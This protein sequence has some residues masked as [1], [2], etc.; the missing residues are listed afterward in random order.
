MVKSC[1]AP[2]CKNR[3]DKSLQ[4]GVTFH[5]FPRN[6]RKRQ[7]WLKQMTES[8]LSTWQPS[9]FSVIC[10]EHFEDASFRYLNGK[11]LVK[12]EAFPTKFSF[13]KEKAEITQLSPGLPIKMSFTPTETDAFIDKLT[14]VDHE[15]NN[16]M[17]FSD[18]DQTTSD[19]QDHLNSIVSAYGQDFVITEQ[20]SQVDLEKSGD[21]AVD[22]MFEVANYPKSSEQIFYPT[23]ANLSKEGISQ[24]IEKVHLEVG[25]D[26]TGHIQSFQPSPSPP[27]TLTYLKSDE[28]TNK[29]KI[30]S[31]KDNI[32]S[33]NID[34]LTHNS[35][36][37]TKTSKDYRGPSKIAKLA[38]TLFRKAMR[39]SDLGLDV[40]LV[41]QELPH[42]PTYWGTKRFTN[43]FILSKPLV[44]IKKIKCYNAEE[45]YNFS[46][47]DKS[48]KHTVDDKKTM[49]KSP[50]FLDS[51]DHTYSLCN[52]SKDEHWKASKSSQ[53]R[54]NPTKNV[55]HDDLLSSNPN[56]SDLV[57]DESNIAQRS[58][59]N[60]LSEK[61]D[62][63]IA[64]NNKICSMWPVFS[65]CK[66]NKEKKIFCLPSETCDLSANSYNTKDCS[67]ND[68]DIGI[69]GAAEQK[70]NKST[71]EIWKKK[72]EKSKL[73]AIE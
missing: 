34:T 6:S 22:I 24:F 29:N 4:K 10:S 60:H 7:K 69:F 2:N 33:E 70:K 63:L 48:K 36:N 51:D 12:D 20:S 71:A 59:K 58:E 16:S 9:A 46:C 11:R 44:D 23:K 41:V 14:K 66:P 42:C 65:A 13:S 57:A 31:L 56:R 45:C 43:N 62:Q 72:C 5:M 8:S 1:A 39:L 3:A 27:K 17:E 35:H 53:T 25:T 52:N 32:T 55:I 26:L 38:I 47:S 50:D 61:I 28:K 68:I 49:N 67:I 19:K 37:K 30:A 15:L 40:F 54:D 18:S 21:L 73:N 64:Q